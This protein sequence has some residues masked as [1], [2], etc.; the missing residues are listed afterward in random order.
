MVVNRFSLEDSMFGDARRSA[1]AT[2]SCVQFQLKLDEHAEPRA[3]HERD[4]TLA[5]E[6]DLLDK[7]PHK[8]VSAWIEQ[9]QEERLQRYGSTERAL[10]VVFAL[11][12]LVLGIG[13]A[14]GVLYYDGR[15]PVN[16][17]RALSL[18][19]VLPFLLLILTLPAM[20]PE[21]LIR[22]IPGAQLFVDFISVLSPGRLQSLFL[23]CLPA[24]QRQQFE[25][26]R[27]QLAAQHTLFRTVRRWAM[28]AITQIVAVF[29][30]LG[31]LGYCLAAITFTDIA[32]VWST[33]LQLPAVDMH[34]LTSLFAAP[35]KS[36]APQA[37]PSLELVTHS[38]YF[39]LGDGNAF[40]DATIAETALLGGW[41]PFLVLSVIT[42]V[43]LPR[44][45]MALFTLYMRNRAAQK[46]IVT[47]PGIDSLLYRMNK[48][49]VSTQALSESNDLVAEDGAPASY[50]C[51]PLELT[52][53]VAAVVW[54]QHE[55]ENEVV[56]QYLHK[57][58]PEIAFE[59]FR[60]GGRLSIEQDE[61]VVQSI[62]TSAPDTK[63][64]LFV[65]AWEPP[66][67]E[68]FDFIKEL[69]KATQSTT[70]IV[71]VPLS[72]GFPETNEA[73]RAEHLSIWQRSVQ[74]V[75][76]PWLMVRQ[77]EV[78]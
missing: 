75:G 4:R 73:I 6:L 65:R 57:R 54:A 14:A 31:V 45:G 1:F 40:P 3:L 30:S 29:F 26:L 51:A 18:L 52:G 49:L 60:A 74:R 7:E 41:W 47:A 36:L 48:P 20:L 35:W 19:V 32:F 56:S 67:A 43:M 61:A 42:Y 21:W 12:G 70:S 44:L 23:R 69:R 34:R 10:S 2:L 33:T 9:L 46:L 22:R 76:D 66:T 24:E 59:L 5:L 50:E 71:I 62:A 63:V 27:G 28:L 17:V 13:L 64:L 8:Q 25:V 55:L 39:R 77:L 37:V 58:S 78:A 72:P 15:H 53:R 16:I 38:R 11:L 68:V